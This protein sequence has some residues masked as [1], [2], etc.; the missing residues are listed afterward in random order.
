MQIYL[1]VFAVALGLALYKKETKLSWVLLL[2]MFIVTAFRAEDVGADTYNYLYEFSHET[3]S[4]IDNSSRLLEFLNLGAYFFVFNYGLDTRYII[5]LYALLSYLCL[6]IIN[7][8]YGIRLSYLLLFFFLTNLFIK[9]LN[10]SRQVVSISILAVGINYIFHEKP[11]KSLIFFL[12][13]ILAGGFHASSYIYVFLYLFRFIR[14]QH[15]KGLPLAAFLVSLIFITGIIPLEPI[16]QQLMPAEYGL[17]SKALSHSYS[18]S[19]IGL[20]FIIFNLAVQCLILY[21]YKGQYF[22]LFAFCIVISSTTVGM[23]FVVGRITLIFSLFSCIVFSQ[24]FGGK[25]LSPTD[26]LLFLFV[27]VTRAYFAYSAIISDPDLVPYVFD[28][29]IITQ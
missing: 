28:F 15:S 10:I 26:K 2:F 23:D 3:G 25:R 24:F 19:L 21:R 4:N 11:R 27:I 9:N 22:L 17:Y 14:I 18:G 20:L 13:V 5:I 12:F 29:S 7:R 1:I 16:L 6:F 8:K